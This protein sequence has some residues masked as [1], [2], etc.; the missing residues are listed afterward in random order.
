MATK[1][2]STQSGLTIAQIDAIQGE[3]VHVE[4]LLAAA[5]DVIELKVSGDG[6]GTLMSLMML[7]GERLERVKTMVGDCQIQVVPHG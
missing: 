1:K 7:A 4:A 6:T 2:V 5:D 3:I